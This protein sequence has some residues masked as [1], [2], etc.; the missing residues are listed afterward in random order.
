MM[1]GGHL[2]TSLLLS[3]GAY[4]YT[5][6][7]PLAAGCILGGFLIDFDHYLDY[8]VFER[9]WRRSSPASFLRYYFTYQLQRV[10]LPLHSLELMIALVAAAVFWPHPVLI[11]Y[12]LGATMHLVFDILINGSHLLKRRVLFYS[13]VYRALQGFSAEKLMDT[14]TV[15]AGTGEHPFLEFFKWRPPEVTRES[16]AEPKT[17]A[18][19]DE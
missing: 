19:P 18:V 17:D 14:I 8:V 13:F 11:G 2:A 7:A 15:P 12:L 1:P 6:S 16:R 9:Q 3:G 4:A 10:V 5:R